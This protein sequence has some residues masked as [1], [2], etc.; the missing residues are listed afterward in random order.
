VEVKVATKRERRKK[1]K[2]ETKNSRVVVRERMPGRFVRGKV[3]G[4]IY[5]AA[6]SMGKQL[7]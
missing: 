1:R 7:T 4:G 5:I 6:G 3:V 2:R